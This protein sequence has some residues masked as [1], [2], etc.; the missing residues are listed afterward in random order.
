MAGNVKNPPPLIAGGNYEN[1]EKSLQLWQLVT[2]LSVEK[3]GPAL[4]LALTGKAKEAVLELSVAE[5]SSATGIQKILEK[6]SRKIQLMQ[7][8]RLLKS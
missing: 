7:R 6:I 1:W 3:Q 5:I 2:E 4:V 8:M